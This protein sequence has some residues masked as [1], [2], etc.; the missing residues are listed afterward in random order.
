MK[1]R[2]FNEAAGTIFVILGLLH[3]LR[4]FQGWEAVINGWKVPM[5]LSFAVVLVAS[6]FALHA[7]NLAKRK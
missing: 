2:A 1:Q 3:L 4:I 7:I 6:F 5:G